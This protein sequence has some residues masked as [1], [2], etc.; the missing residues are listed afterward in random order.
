[1]GDRVTESQHSAPGGKKGLN[2][3]LLLNGWY[4]SDHHLTTRGDASGRWKGERGRDGEA[5]DGN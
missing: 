4:W 3:R 5:A 2:G 1:M